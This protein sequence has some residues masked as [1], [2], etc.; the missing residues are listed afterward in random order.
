MRILS[1]CTDVE[2]CNYDENATIDDG[3]CG[4]WIVQENVAVTL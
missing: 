1:A 4:P 3:S 2:A